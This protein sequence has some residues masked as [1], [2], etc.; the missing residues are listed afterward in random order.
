MVAGGL[1][2]HRQAWDYTAAAL[3][4]RVFGVGDRKGVSMRNLSH[5][6]RNFVSSVA[7]LV[8]FGGVICSAH[9]AASITGLGVYSGKTESY[10]YGMDA[11]GTVVVGESRVTG[12]DTQAVRWTAATG[13]L[14]LER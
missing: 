6:S 4:A 1:R 7:A 2:T 5:S 10:G 13:M 11:A 8:A 12:A 14:G 9:G 3:R